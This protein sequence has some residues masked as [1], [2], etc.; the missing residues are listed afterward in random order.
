MNIWEPYTPDAKTPWTLRRV[1]HLHRRAAF[2]APWDELQRDLADGPSK[3]AGRLLA[4]TAD[5]HT[6][7]DFAA[8][9]QVFL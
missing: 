2:A 5:A 9:A 3:A 6:P 8:T 1:I 7:A 4:G